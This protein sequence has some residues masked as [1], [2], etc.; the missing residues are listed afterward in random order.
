M[1]KVDIILL[2]SVN[3]GFGGQK[4]IPATLE[5]AKEARKLIDES[6]YDISLQIDGGVSAAN[7]KE[8]PRRASTCS[9]P[10]PPSSSPTTRRSSTTCA[11]SSRRCR[12]RQEVSG[13][14][15]TSSTTD[16]KLILDVESR[17]G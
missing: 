12:C 17:N 8:I 9:S 7:I 2:M 16:L 11:A 13:A 6:G 4:F 5:K 1:D 10:A 3:P 14:I 15:R